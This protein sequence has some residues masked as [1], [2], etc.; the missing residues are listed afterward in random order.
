MVTWADQEFLKRNKKKTARK[1]DIF[2]E[3]NFISE[4]LTLSFALSVTFSS[5]LSVTFFNTGEFGLINDIILKPVTSRIDPCHRKKAVIQSCLVL[6]I[7][8]VFEIYK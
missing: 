8:A 3:F 6:H 2:E 1:Q 7:W 5:C 4:F